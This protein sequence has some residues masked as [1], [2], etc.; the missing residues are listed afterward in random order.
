[1]A[2]PATG[3]GCSRDLGLPNEVTL[4][5]LLTRILLGCLLSACAVPRATEAAR[6]GV[7]VPAQPDVAADLALAASDAEPLG[8][9]R[10]WQQHPAILQLAQPAELWV[11][12]DVHGDVQRLGALLQV[13]GL[14]Q[15]PSGAQTPTWLGGSAVLVA[16]G[17]LIDKGSQGLAVIAGLQALAVQ[18][19]AQGGA[20][21]VLLGNHEAEFLANPLE[22][23]V[24]EFAAELAQTGL[25]PQFVAQGGHPIGAWLRNLP[26]GLRSG[27][28]FFC[29]GG[30]TH[31]LTLD[32]LR[33]SIEQGVDT[34]GFGAPVLVAPDS[35]LEARLDPPWWE[36]PGMTPQQA[37][38]Q[39]VAAL[40]AE[41]I[42]QGHQPGKVDFADGTKRKAGQLYQKYGRIFLVD[43]GMSQAVDDSTGALLHIHQEPGV[44]RA[45]AV[46]ADGSLKQLWSAP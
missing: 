5:S 32:Q 27:P 38:D 30:D 14:A 17:D 7:D 11:V 18:A 19:S 44:T 41:H 21:V 31:G 8:G 12:G 29:H 15:W 26:I 36:V 4:P 3:E 9:Q 45:I 35:L 39:R 33:S 16:M 6:I 25:D 43:V 46:G 13:A 1:M 20:V 24:S 2:E 10:N 37:L 28:W 34:Q 40:G 22:S 42:V 23:K